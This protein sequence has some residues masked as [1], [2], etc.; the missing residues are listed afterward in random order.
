MEYYNNDYFDWQ[1]N[2]GAFGGE[3]NLFKFENFISPSDNVVDF[4]AGGGYL[5]NHIKNH[6]KIGIEI[7]DV[8]RSNAE[9]FGLKMVANILDV[10]CGTG[11]VLNEVRTVLICVLCKTVKLE[12]I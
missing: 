2:I 8:A 6:N 3:A 12:K 5:L 9:K 10:G 7:N 1:K 4:G 11:L